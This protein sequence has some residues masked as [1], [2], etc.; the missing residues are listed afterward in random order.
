MFFF[1]FSSS[2]I[3]LLDCTFTFKPINFSNSIIV[4]ISFTNGTFD[5]FTPLDNIDVAKIGRHAF[6]DPEIE[7]DPEISFFPLISNFC[8]KEVKSLEVSRLFVSYIFPFFLHKS[9]LAFRC[10]L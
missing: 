7:I 3:F 2:I 9:L 6:L 5:I 4:K 8:I 10:L 1:L